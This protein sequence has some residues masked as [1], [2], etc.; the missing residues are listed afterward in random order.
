MVHQLIAIILEAVVSDED[1]IIR[2]N[3]RDSIW[4]RVLSLRG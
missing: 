1:L 3:V 2:F 4:K